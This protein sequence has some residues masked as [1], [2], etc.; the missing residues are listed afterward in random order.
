MYIHVM[1]T[2]YYDWGHE[3]FTPNM[4]LRAGSIHR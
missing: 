3:T 2:F 4:A 1:M